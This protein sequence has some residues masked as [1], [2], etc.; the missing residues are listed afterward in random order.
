MAN[1]LVQYGYLQLLDLLT[2]LAFLLQGV[3]E[4]NPVV[5]LAMAMLPHPIW[6]LVAVKCGA[7]ILGLYC[8]R[9]DKF[10]LL[11]RVN[12]MFAVLI[13]WNLIALILG[14][15]FHHGGRLA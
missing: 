3:Q 9:N 13:A 1:P 7:L 12:L 8:W 4:G 15:V 10:R 2:T 5:R 6:G 14:S 11:D